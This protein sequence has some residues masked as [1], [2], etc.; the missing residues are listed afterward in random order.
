MVTGYRDT[1]VDNHFRLR[2]DAG[3]PDQKVG[4]ASDQPGLMVD[5]ER[6]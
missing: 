4:D 2:A 3:G 1:F 6:R 5:E